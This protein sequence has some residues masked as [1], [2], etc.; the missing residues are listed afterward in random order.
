MSVPY[1]HPTAV[2]DEDVHLGEGTKIWHFC[3]IGKGVRF[4]TGC[5]AGQNVFVAD[6]VRIGDRVRIQNNVSVYQGVQLLDDVFVGPSCVFTN[7]KRPRP[8]V[9]GRPD[10]ESTVVQEGVTLGANATIVCGVTLGAYAFVGAGS[11]VTRDVS[12]H[13]MVVGNPAKPVGWVCRCGQGLQGPSC[14]FCGREYD[15]DEHTC[16]L[17]P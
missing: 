1:V 13:A 7:A 4:G 9:V 5:V 12:S 15:I 17:R 2:I 14:E 6:G 11:V 10:Y 16:R 8:S 3:H